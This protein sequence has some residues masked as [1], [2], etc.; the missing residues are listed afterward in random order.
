[1]TETY[2]YARKI[3]DGPSV[4]IQTIKRATYQSSRTDLRTALDLVSSHMGVIRST[5]DHQ[6]TMKA[7]LERLKSKRES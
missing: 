1:M 7:A 3:A 6:E 5:K 4:I 2:N